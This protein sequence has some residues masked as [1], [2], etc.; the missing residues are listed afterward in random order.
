PGRGR[1]E[2][3][4]EHHRTG[5]N[6]N[7]RQQRYRGDRR[8]Q[9][10]PG[11]TRVCKATDPDTGDPCT[12]ASPTPCG[13]HLFGAI[14]GRL[15]RGK[16]YSVGIRVAVRRYSTTAPLDRGRHPPQRESRRGEP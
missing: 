5:E 11:L 16:P 3:S 15:D 8:F 4:P 13:E 9:L 2:G 6:P 12:G 10:S 1:T 7:L 14:A